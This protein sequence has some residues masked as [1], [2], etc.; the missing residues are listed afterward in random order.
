MNDWLAKGQAEAKKRNRKIK[1]AAKEATKIRQHT[2]DL[3]DK[4]TVEPAEIEGVV[5]RSKLEALWY[6]EFKGCDSFICFECVQVPLLIDGR[7]GQFQATYEP[8]FH[9][10]LSDNTSVYVELKPNHKLAMAD[11]RQK[12]ALDLNPKNRFVVIG[13]YPYSQRG[14]TVRMLTG[15]KESVHRYI[16]VAEVLS[17]LGC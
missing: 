12:R 3:Y 16:Q 6:E 15:D 2:Q 7:F 13:G 9:I 4:F 1:K 10:I 11:D 17:F 14:V 5:F 8:D